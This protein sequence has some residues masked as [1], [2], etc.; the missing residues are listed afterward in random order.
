MLPILII[1]SNWR[2]AKYESRAVRKATIFLRRTR[3]R[4]HLNDNKS[5]EKGKKRNAPIR[6]KA[7]REAQSFPSEEEM[8]RNN[9]RAGGGN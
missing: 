2:R 5:K 7:K 9:W 8:V 1:S 3:R 4:R 6:L